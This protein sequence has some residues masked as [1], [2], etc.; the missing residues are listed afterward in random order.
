MKRMTQLLACLAA[1]SLLSHTAIAQSADSSK[2]KNYRNIVRYNLSG[3]LLFGFG[4]VIVVG[5]ER[6]LKKNQSF[7]FNFGK[8]AI[9]KLIAIVTDSSVNLQRD[10]KNTG[11]N[12]SFDYRFYLKKEN[13]Y[14]PPHGLYIG[15]YFSYNHFERENDIS[16]KH[17]NGNVDI[18]KTN[19]K[20][21]IMSWGAEMG[22]QFV[23]WKRLA[24]DMLLIGPG[25]GS[26]DINAKLT[27]NIDTKEREKL[28]GAVQQVLTKRFPGL[29]TIFED[30]QISSD[31]K[32]Q[33]WDIGF[34]YVI[35]V[36]FLF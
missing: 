3:P 1:I 16:L 5:Y 35:H 34:R 17:S 4:N 7:S 33:T 19:S 2:P 30:K 28:N 29:S 23:L 24:L 26:Y 27:G 31:G 11:Y 8:A 12:F 10:S 32:L 21:T 13:K 22:Y 36:G 14:D 6:V 15:P 9:P 25:V 18:V 20:F